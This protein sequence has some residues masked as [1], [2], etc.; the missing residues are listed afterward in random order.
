MEIIKFAKLDFRRVKSQFKILFIL[1]AISIFLACRLQAG[2]WSLMYMCFAGLLLSTTPFFLELTNQRGF[3]NLL[4]AKAASRAW[5]R[6]LFGTIYIAM[7][8]AVGMVTV[9]INMLIM[10]KEVAY[11]TE[12]AIAILAVSV[13][14]NSLQYLF[15]SFST[16]KNVQLL[17]LLRMLPPFLMF[18]GGNMVIEY[19]NENQADAL[20]K[21]SRT[22][23]YVVEHRT[24]MAFF[25]LAVSL[26]VTL[27]AGSLAA[28]HEKKLEE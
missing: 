16:I 20:D 26:I 8:F 10:K 17:S 11:L 19:I 18:F 3:F 2:I 24:G 25:F 12:T 5:G 22:I 14:L 21:V 27:L 9:L 28:W 1:F 4:P 15:L 6:Y 13:L 7:L 23:R